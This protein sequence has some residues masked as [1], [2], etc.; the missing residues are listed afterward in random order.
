MVKGCVPQI[1]ICLTGSCVSFPALTFTL[2]GEYT[3]DS[4]GLKY[5]VSI[6]VYNARESLMASLLSLIWQ[7]DVCTHQLPHVHAV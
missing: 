1:N 2:E 7:P 4:L 6:A 3:W 5:V